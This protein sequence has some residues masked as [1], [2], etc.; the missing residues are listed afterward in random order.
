MP[1]IYP[2]K[3]WRYD[4]SL[5]PDISKVVAP[6]YDVITK[7]GQSALYDSSL[8]NFVR[9]ILNKSAGDDRYRQAAKAL[10]RWKSFGIVRQ[11]PEPVFYLLSQSFTHQG[12]PVNR[13]GF[14]AE[15]E[16]EP[17][18]GDILPH[19]Q[20]IDK[21]VE[22]RFRLMEA[23]GTNSGQIFMCYRDPSMAVES[24]MTEME[25]SEPQIDATTGDG[26]RYRLW[27]IKETSQIQEI[28]NI[29]KKTKV[30][31]ADG[32]HRYRTA[33]R[34]LTRYPDIPG[35]DRVMVTLVNSFNPGLNVLPTHRLIK[36]CDKALNEIVSDLERHFNV[37][38]YPSLESLLA[39]LDNDV[40]ANEVCLGL[41]HR[42]SG[43]PLALFFKAFE[44][45]AEEFPGHS[46]TFRRLPVN[47]FHNFVLKKV[48][49]LDSTVQRDLERLE[50]LRGTSDPREYLLRNEDYEIAGLVK[51]PDLNAIFA[52]A[53]EGEIMPQKATFFYPKVYSGFVFRCFGE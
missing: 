33:H 6:P 45:L 37:R 42:E 31:I 16:L 18:G 25:K 27:L 23:T 44:Q 51:P 50:Y 49:G 41:Y 20:T 13:V 2:F 32:H 53:E 48:L 19:E 1:K 47:I 10:N 8:Y 43:T 22:D 39:F 29:L 26:V 38:Q 21:H 52:V 24:I 3:G 35:S 34:F 17:L 14:I 28:Q 40:G 5:V 4:I 46:D 30:I 7:E 36:K 11:D 15:M 12:K 9:I